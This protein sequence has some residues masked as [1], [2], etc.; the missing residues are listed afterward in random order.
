MDEFIA[1]VIESSP[2]LGIVVYIIY[3]ANSTGKQMLEAMQRIE[4]KLDHLLRGKKSDQD[5]T[6]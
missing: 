2:L 3:L 1:R 6:Y 5:T 4:A